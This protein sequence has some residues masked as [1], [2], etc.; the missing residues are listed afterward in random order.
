MIDWADGARVKT[1]VSSVKGVR[2]GRQPENT[3]LDDQFPLRRGT[4]T[5]LRRREFG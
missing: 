5:R 3:V 1:K 4:A 2:F